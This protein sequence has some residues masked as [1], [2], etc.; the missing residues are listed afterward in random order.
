MWKRVAESQ[1]FDK[2]NLEIVSKRPDEFGELGKVFLVM[3][4]VIYSREQSW[5]QLVEN[6]KSEDYDSQKLKKSIIRKSQT[7]YLEQLLKKARSWRTDIKKSSDT[8]TV[9]KLD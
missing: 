7:I 2:I 9:S 6:L 1:E 4:E 3:G 5:K 8:N